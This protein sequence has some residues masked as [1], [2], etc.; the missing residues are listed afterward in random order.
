MG[1]AFGIMVERNYELDVSDGRRK[2]KY[3]VVFQGNN[4]H[5]ANWETACFE[6]AGSSPASM[7]AGKVV[8]CYSLYP[9]NEGEQADA[10]QAY[11]QSEWTGTPTWVELP[12]EAWPPEWWNKDGTAKYIRPVVLMRKA[13][14]G[15]PDSGTVW[16][17]HCEAKLKEIGFEPVTSW[18]STFWHEGLKLLLTV[19]VDDLKM[20]GPKGNL[21]KGWELITTK[22]GIGE[23][24]PASLYLGCIH[25]KSIMKVEGVGEVS[26]MEYNM[27]CYLKQIVDDYEELASELTDQRVKL[28][29]VTT[30]FLDED[31]S[32]ADARAPIHPGDP[33]IDCPYCRHSFSPMADIKTKD[34]LLKYL[35]S[36]GNKVHHQH[37]ASPTLQ[38]SEPGVGDSSN[39]QSGVSKEEAPLEECAPI[40]E[41]TAAADKKKPKFEAKAK[42]TPGEIVMP[43]KKFTKAFNKIRSKAAKSKAKSA[44]DKVDRGLLG[45]LAT[46]IL[47]R[48][49]YAAREA[50]FD[51]LRAVNKMS[52]NVAYWNA[53]S[54]LRMERLVSY[55]KSSLH[56]RQF[57]WIGDKSEL[58][59]PHAYTDADFAGCTRT[60]RSTTGIQLQVEGP[61]HAF[62]LLPP[63]RDSRM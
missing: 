14:Y 39:E 40:A 16:E 17:R 42:T 45:P 28:K 56:Y 20:A 38:G 60:L 25:T 54:D 2:M 53:E 31:C 57:G 50:R 30:P 58:L 5:T 9:G 48:I 10:E 1:R 12:E 7:E 46:S 29:E 37:C 59:Q 61:H 26:V 22:I 32:R 52:C 43:V 51:L 15:H 41:I 62:Q 44:E 6:D 19:Y 23:V 49:L 63:P 34:E 13:L 24:T 21:A 27:E 11:I 8:D 47:M 33:L 55:I 3:G 18:A 4:V 36:K 35:T